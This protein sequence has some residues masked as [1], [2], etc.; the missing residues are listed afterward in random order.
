MIKFREKTPKRAYQKKHNNYRD[1]KPYLA[2]DFHYR[3]GYTDCIDFWFGGKHNFHIDH[4]LPKKKYPNLEN[5]YSNLVYACSYVNILKSD[6]VGNY[7][8]PCNEDFNR[9]FY[10]DNMGCIYPRQESEQAIYMYKKLKLYLARYSIIWTLEQLEAKINKLL[11]LKKTIKN[12]ES[13]NEINDM[14]VDLTG[15]FLEYKNYL[16]NNNNY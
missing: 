15:S 8:D 7:L 3:C 1:Y 4:F 11:S 13:I 12:I 10:R 16:N 9:H 2:E 6:D 14:I 5:E